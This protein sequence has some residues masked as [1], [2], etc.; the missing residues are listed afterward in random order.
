MLTYQKC[1]SFLTVVVEENMPDTTDVSDKGHFAKIKQ[2]LKGTIS[3]TMPH[4]K[5]KEK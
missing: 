4:K 2:Q 5:E 3:R 1:E